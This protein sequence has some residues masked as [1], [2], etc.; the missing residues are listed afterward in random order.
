MILQAIDI[1]FEDGTTGIIYVPPDLVDNV[2]ELLGL[3]PEQGTT[4]ISA[5]T[6]H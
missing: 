5:E 4:I 3:E 1:E 6:R 2:L